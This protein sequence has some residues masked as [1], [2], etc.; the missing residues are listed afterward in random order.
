ME[1]MFGEMMSR[2]EKLETKV[3]SGL[4]KKGREARKKESVAGNSIEGAEDD[5]NRGS[6]FCIYRNDLYEARP[7]RGGIRPDMD[8]GHRRNFD[9]LGDLH[10][11]LGSIKLKITAFKGKTNPEAYLEWE[12]KVEINF[13]IH[14]YSEEKKVKLAVVEFTD[15][16]MV[17]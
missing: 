5:F 13:D 11:N 4:G 15:Y 10:R 17:W 2:F 7:M 6:E 1:F 9:D 8:S 14:R 12:R 3:E 16:A